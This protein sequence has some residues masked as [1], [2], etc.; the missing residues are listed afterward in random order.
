MNPP[1]YSADVDSDVWTSVVSNPLRRQIIEILRTA[2]RPVAIADLA[3]QLARQPNG[4]LDDSDR[5]RAQEL[6]VT[7]HHRHLPKLDRVGLV[8]YDFTTQTVAPA[9]STT[10]SDVKLRVET[11]C[12]C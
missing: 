10:S 3:M 6:R 7:L 4:D 1:E 5:E 11:D 9:R 8:E 12:D 2:E